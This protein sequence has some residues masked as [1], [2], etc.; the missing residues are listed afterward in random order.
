MVLAPHIAHRI[1]KKRRDAVVNVQSDGEYG[2]GFVV[3][4][5]N[6]KQC[7]ILTNAHVVGDG[8]INKTAVV[9]LYPNNIDAKRSECKTIVSGWERSHNVVD[10]FVLLNCSQE[11]FKSVKHPFDLPSGNEFDTRGTIEVYR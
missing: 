1:S 10:D 4:S 2:S 8:Q 7:L 6:T 9:S 11:F 3:R 5:Q